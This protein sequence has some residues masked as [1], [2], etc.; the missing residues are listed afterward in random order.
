MISSIYTKLSLPA[1]ECFLPILHAYIL[2]ISRIVF[3]SDE[4]ASGLNLAVEES[5]KNIIQY[6]YPDSRSGEVFFDMEIRPMELVLTIGDEGLPLHGSGLKIIRHEVDEAHFEN[7]GAQGNVL[8][9]VKR[10]PRPV[11][12]QPERFV[13][14]AKMA[15]H[16]NY[17]IRP[18]RIEEAVQLTKLLWLTYGYSYR[19]EFYRP[20]ELIHM[21][22]R[23]RM[24]SY[25]AVAE[26]GLVVGHM[27]LVRGEAALTAEK[28]TLAVAPA[29]RHRGMMDALDAAIEAKAMEMGL[30][31]ISVSPATSHIIS[32]KEVMDKGYKLCGLELA[33]F[34][35]LQFK[36]IDKED[37]VPQRE[38]LLHCFKYL[39]SPP[40]A[41]VHIP[42]RHR[43]MVGRIYENIGQP[44]WVGDPAPSSVPGD[45]R[46]SFDRNLQKGLI[47][48]ISADLSQWPVILRAAE[49][50]EN[51]G[52]AEVVHLDLPM[53]Q[54]ASALISEL[55][56]KAGFFFSG[57]RPSEAKCGDN[58]RLQRFIAPL[59]KSRI[60]IYSGF[61]KELCDYV[62]SQMEKSGES[63]IT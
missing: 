20:E 31:G 42:S 41:V 27:G 58:L 18:M 25:V 63:I 59:D 45:Y 23:G 49:D 52:G 46:V 10:L 55:A 26:N 36:T 35:P 37:S 39:R 1:D 12:V 2:E 24:I 15:P 56:E 7:L 43:A 22:E 51:F 6:A 14:D 19:K 47:S 11:E 33:A 9:L 60:N 8:R 3:L 4:D 28:A 17:E 62:M 54:P 16:Q 48:V 30:L 5:F 34:M 32:Q 13:E 38:S 57:I 50:L 40:P 61:G 21:M 53:A 44:C 29:H